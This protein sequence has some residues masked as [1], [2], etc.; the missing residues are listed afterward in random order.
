MP[1]SSITS[2]DRVEF[3]DA[4][5]I[6]VSGYVNY[7]G[8][9]CFVD[10]VE[11]YVDGKPTEPKTMTNNLGYYSVELDPGRDYRI[12]AIER[13]GKND[14]VVKYYD[15]VS[16][17][18]PVSLPMFIDRTKR[19]LTGLVAAALLN[20]EV[21]RMV[22]DPLSVLL[23]G[24]GDHLKVL[25][26]T[27]LNL[28][29][30]F[31]IEAWVYPEILTGTN[32]ILSKGNSQYTLAIKD[33][34]LAFYSL[35]TN[36]WK[37]S[38]TRIVR[39]TWTHVAV[40]FGFASGTRTYTLFVNGKTAGTFSE[41][42]TTN[43][44]SD[45]LALYLG[46]ENKTA[47]ANY[48]KGNIAEV[49]LW[50]RTLDS[51]SIMTKKLQRLFPWKENGLLAYYTF[52][53]ESGNSLTQKYNA[54]FVNSVQVEGFPQ[55]LVQTMA[56][57]VSLISGSI[58]NQTKLASPFDLEPT[59]VTVRAANGCLTKTVNVNADGTFTVTGL[60]PN[61]YIVS[62]MH[63]SM[64]VTNKLLPKRE[65]LLDENKYTTFDFRAPLNAEIR[66][67]N[68]SSTSKDIIVP[69]RTTSSGFKN[70]GKVLELA[71]GTEK[72]IEIDH[73]RGNRGNI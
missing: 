52:S 54:A 13:P 56:G 42:N 1:P 25:P 40:T 30:N 66:R 27:S 64:V 18:E 67:M 17:T 16:L 58:T 29:N 68:V 32:V 4:T 19:T 41:P 46:V 39:N 47:L 48:F 43:L 51:N 28:R 22:N 44:P 6:P 55:P 31:S 36:S 9:E 11:I 12:S 20:K 62:I 61:Y 53:G 37:R 70:I 26:D 8:T 65:N 14:F 49:R 5:V 59:K 10:S 38:T 57:G 33:S 15:V 23:D 71:S 50:N 34:M 60:P 7:Q 24:V 69:D 73:S 35:D 21:N 45:N 63:P 72:E 3:I 2:V